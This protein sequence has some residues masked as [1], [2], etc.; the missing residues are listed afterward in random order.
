MSIYYFSV[1]ERCGLHLY[2]REGKWLWMEKGT[3]KPMGGDCREHACVEGRNPQA[4]GLRNPGSKSLYLAER[5]VFKVEL[6][7]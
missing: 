2:K 5:D 7:P 1:Y 4:S 3:T 6:L